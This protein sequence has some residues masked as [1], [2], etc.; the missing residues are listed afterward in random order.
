M[1]LCAEKRLEKMA[2]LKGIHIHHT[3]VSYRILDGVK[4]TTQIQRREQN[5]TIRI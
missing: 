5:G 3:D 4:A 1:K 2:T